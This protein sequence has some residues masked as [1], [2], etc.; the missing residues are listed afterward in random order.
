MAGLTK[1]QRAERLAA[2]KLL[3]S[4]GVSGSDAPE[5]PEPI[6]LV[7]MVLDSGWPVQPGMPTEAE[8]H[9]EEVDRWLAEGW[10]IAE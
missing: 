10:R 1:E 6:T 7:A 2:E 8:V 3:A 4:G 9:P 5:Q